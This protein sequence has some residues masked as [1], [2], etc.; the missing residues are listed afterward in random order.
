[1]CVPVWVYVTACLSVAASA[2]RLS[3]RRRRA[4]TKDTR[5]LKFFKSSNHFLG[6]FLL[7]ERKRKYQLLIVSFMFQDWFK[8]SEILAVKL[9]TRVWWVQSKI[10][11]RYNVFYRYFFFRDSGSIDIVSWSTADAS[12][13]VTNLYWSFVQPKST[14]TN[15]KICVSQL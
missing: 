2:V 15:S 14:K 1:V 9:K 12:K 11:F 10:M 7:C 4:I 3:S 13:F 8:S 6:I 5:L